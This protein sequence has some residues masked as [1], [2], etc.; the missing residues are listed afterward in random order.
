MEETFD[1]TIV[2]AC[3]LWR[4]SSRYWATGLRQMYRS[5]S[6]A[7]F[8]RSLQ[9]LVP[10]LTKEDIRPGGAGVRAQA[11]DND[12]KLVDDFRFLHSERETQVCNVPSPAATASL[13]NRTRRGRY[14]VGAF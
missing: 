4:M 10:E 7:A 6:K 14:S 3:S 11:V 9:K 2:G 8:T 12:G 13:P 5:W 1:I